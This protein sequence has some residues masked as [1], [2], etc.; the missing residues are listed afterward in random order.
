MAK[1]VIT[2]STLF[3]GAILLCFFIYNKNTADL[4]Q[5]YYYLSKQEAVDV[6][7]PDCE[8]IV[9]KSA[10]RNV[11]Q[12][13]LIRGDVVAISKNDRFILAAQAPLRFCNDKALAV[14]NDTL[15]KYFIIDKEHN[16][17]LGPYNKAEYLHKKADLAVPNTLN[18]N[19]F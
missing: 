6:G 9:Y 7:Y 3:V 16:L 19:D 18:L 2:L 8:S 1:I 13:V 4:G 15:L 14:E 5:G 11:F 10:S 17:V 12:N